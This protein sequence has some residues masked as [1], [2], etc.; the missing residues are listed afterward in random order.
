MTNRSVERRTNYEQHVF[1]NVD[2]AILKEQERMTQLLREVDANLEALQRAL[3]AEASPEHSFGAESQVGENKSVD[4]IAHARALAHQGQP[5]ATPANRR[6]S[7]LRKNHRK[8][9]P[10]TAGPTFDKLPPPRV[11]NRKNAMMAGLAPILE[12][13]N[14]GY[15]SGFAPPIV[16]TMHGE[17]VMT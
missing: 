9:P 1:V 8:A 2:D 13:L 17:M 10:A 6:K 11:V 5:E 16:M 4:S 14:P 12:V 7:C 15:N 3:V